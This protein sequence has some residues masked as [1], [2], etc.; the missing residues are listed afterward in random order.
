MTFSLDSFFDQ[1][2]IMSLSAD[3]VLV[4]WGEARRC[5][6]YELRSSC[7]SF[8][9]TDYFL[10]RPDPW[11]QY[12]HSLVASLDELDEWLHQN[13]FV[14]NCSWTFHQAGQFKGACQELMSLLKQGILKKAVPYLFAQSSDS[15]TKK[16]L[17]QSIKKSLSVLRKHK[18]YL[19]GHWDQ[20]GG[21]LGI[22]PEL[23]FSYD[24]KNSKMVETMAVAG[25]CDS[26]E[27]DE[28]LFLRNEK[29][30]HE[31][32][33]VV[34]GITNALSPFGV[35]NHGSTGLLKLPKL[36]HLF[37]PIHLNLH[38]SF[39][40]DRLVEALHPTPALGAFPIPE[41]KKWLEQYAKH[42]PRGSFGA[43]IGYRDPHSGMSNCFVAIRNVQWNDEGMRIGAGCG[44]VKQSV[45]EN[46]WKEVQMKIRAT[47]DQLCL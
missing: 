31:H 12:S 2:A 10:G 7:P 22:S 43:P 17:C 30:R 8:Y 5:T 19:Y 38:D 9:A 39:E 20:S 23:L 15:M 13:D 40:F 41:G 46:E 26:S 4:A 29:E 18:G 11:I 45:F 1:G 28:A 35:V 3:R 34:E 21:I 36:T 16:R 14:T 6:S 33:L 42:T 44:V 25:T 47:R 27:E 24:E 32:Q 37:T